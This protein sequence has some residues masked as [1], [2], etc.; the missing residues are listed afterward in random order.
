[1]RILSIMDDCIP[2]GMELFTAVDEEQLKYI[3]RIIDNCDY[4]LL[5]VAGRYGTPASDGVSFTEKEYEYAVERGLPVIAVVQAA[6]NDIAPEKS[7]KD[8]E[9]RERLEAFRRRVKSGRLV[10]EYT[11]PG[12]LPGLVAASMHHAI[13]HHPAVGWIRADRVATE[14]PPSDREQLQKDYEELAKE[15]DALK[16]TLKSADTTEAIAEFVRRIQRP[17]LTG[18]GD[19]DIRAGKRCFRV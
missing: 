15:V 18:G 9:R 16:P 12:D 13:R 11:A 2:A 4:Y 10:R 5:L 19:V 17:Y 6:P 14:D 1:M 7:E 3:K 8:P